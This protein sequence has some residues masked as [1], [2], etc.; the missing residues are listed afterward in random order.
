MGQLTPPPRKQ[1]KKRVTNNF[2]SA[3]DGMVL[4]GES[5]GQ[6]TSLGVI[7]SVGCLPQQVL[8]VTL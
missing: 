4:S 5:F 7:C 1:T 6:A 8:Q 3:V 2:F